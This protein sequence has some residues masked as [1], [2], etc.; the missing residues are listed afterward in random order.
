[1]RRGIL[2]MAASLALV[3]GAIAAAPPFPDLGAA[4]P[5]RL[6]D[7]GSGRP[8][9]PQLAGKSV[10]VSFIASTCRETCPLT[11]GTFVR[12]AQALQARGDLRR[13]GLV[14]VTIDPTTDTIDR[15]RNL[16]RSVD[17]RNSAIHF[18]TGSPEQID[19]ILRRYD[20]SVRYHAGTREDPDHTAAIYLIDANGHVRYDFGID[21]PPSAI[22]RLT[23]RFAHLAAK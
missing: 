7:A 21:Y 11:E 1:M 2:Q 6:T 10:L 20:I 15:L 22:A 12:V 14:L 16:A 8:L 18:A 17:G 5:L 3:I 23:D 4:A 13:V 9:M 19:D